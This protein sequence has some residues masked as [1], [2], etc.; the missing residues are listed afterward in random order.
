MQIQTTPVVPVPDDASA[1]S[2]RP[3]RRPSRLNAAWCCRYC[4]KRDC[5]SPRCIEWYENAV[6]DVCPDCD[7]ATAPNGNWD[8]F[9]NTCTDG[10]VE[11]EAPHRPRHIPYASPSMDGAR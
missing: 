10:I 2:Y 7:G 11:Y 9:C 5:T 6:W 3:A 8:A 1:I 4:T